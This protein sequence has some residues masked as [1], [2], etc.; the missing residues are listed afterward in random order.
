MS[1]YHFRRLKSTFHEPITCLTLSI[2]LKVL[3]YT[4]KLHMFIYLIFLVFKLSGIP[5]MP[6][7]ITSLLK[8]QIMTVDITY[9]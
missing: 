6:L 7:E 5:I 1:T 8:K 3:V 9:I 4:A 2:K